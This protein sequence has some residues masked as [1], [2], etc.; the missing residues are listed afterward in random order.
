VDEKVG[1]GERLL[2]ID[3]CG[4]AAGVALCRESDVLRVEEFAERAAS[5]GIV[6]AV[7]RLLSAEGWALAQLDGIGVVNG[8][9]SFTGVRVGLAAA[10]GLCEAASLPLAAVSRLAVLARAAR[11]DAGFAVLSAGRDELYVRDLATGG[12]W[13]CGVDEFSALAGGVQVVA[14]ESRVA[15]RLAEMKPLLHS[16]RVSDALELVRRSL[17]EDGCDVAVI[18]ANY[19][20]GESQI[21]RKNAG[22]S[23]SGAGVD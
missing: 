6:G 23:K 11:V 3:T 20:R 8:P 2:L 17:R 22:V 10:K 21:Y 16:L 7:R 13:M 4:E 12:E 15:E 18:D 1:A 14:A 19:V 5:V 9:G